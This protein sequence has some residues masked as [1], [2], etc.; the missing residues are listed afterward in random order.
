MGPDDII[1]SDVGVHKMWIARHYH[2]HS[3]NT[4][5]ISNG[6]VAMGISIPGALAAKLMYLH[7]KVVAATGDGGFMMNC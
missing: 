3:P 6:F 4:W 5:I 1:I 2:C 7:R